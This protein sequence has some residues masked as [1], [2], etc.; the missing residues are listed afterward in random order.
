MNE[1]ALEEK[2]E[3]LMESHH[4][5]VV[6]VCGHPNV[7]SDE[8]LFGEIKKMLSSFDVF[9][10]YVY[11]HINNPDIHYDCSRCPLRVQLL[12]EGKVGSGGGID[13]KKIAIGGSITAALI[14]FGYA[15]NEL[16][17]AITAAINGG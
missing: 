17:K 2:I 1:R 8:G 7:P 3:K 11:S 15:I 12:A 14:G 4:D 6:A 5:L 9:K 13:K 16:V 10:Q